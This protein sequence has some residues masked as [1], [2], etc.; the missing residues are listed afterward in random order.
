MWFTQDMIVLEEGG[1]E[2]YNAPDLLNFN[3]Q[4]R[5]P[6]FDVHASNSLELG[7]LSAGKYLFKAVMHDK[8][9]KVDASYTF[10][11]EVIN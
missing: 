8:L 1:E 5:S 11:F 6:V 4:T 7:N 3:Y 10:K 2:L 9:K